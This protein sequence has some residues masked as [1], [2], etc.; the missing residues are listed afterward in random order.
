M[1]LDSA[2]SAAASSPLA[3]WDEEM[4][5][6]A[7]IGRKAV[8]R[9]LVVASAGNISV[10]KP[11]LEQFIVTGTGTLLDE[12]DET[13]FAVMSSSGVHMGGIAPSSEWKLHYEVYKQRPD[14]TVVMHLHPE[15]SVL[16]DAMRI[17]IRQFML[18]HVAYIPKI[19]RIPFYPN[20]SDELA[21][22][23]ARATADC[24]CVILGNHGCS[25]VSTSLTDAF[26]KAQ[27]LEQAARMTFRATQLGDTTTEFPQDLRATAIHK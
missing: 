23:A 14:A 11:E 7:D 6:I 15:M 12:L 25:V 21:I 9:G 10:R 20:G 2:A 3:A 1:L 22:E 18:D 16:L 24:D 4:F 17:P 27:N 19:A 26:R 8:E 5:D 13:Q